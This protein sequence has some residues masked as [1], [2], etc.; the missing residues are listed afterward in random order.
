METHQRNKNANAKIMG[1][2]GQVFLYPE[3]FDTLLYFSQLLQAE[4]IRCG[5]EHWRRNRTR[6][7]G[8]VYWQLDDCWPTASWSS[9]DYFG[10]WKALHYVAKRFFSPVMISCLEN[11][12]PI[13]GSEVVD[14]PSLVESTARL[15]VV[16]ESRQPVEGT[17][18]W[19]LCDAESR[20]LQQGDE[21]L[22]IQAL[23]VAWL[24]KMVFTGIDCLRDHLSF[25]YEVG[26]AIISSGSVLFTAPKHY[27]FEQPRLRGTREGDKLV[28]VA[29]RFAKWVEIIPDH[30]AVFSDNF[31]DMEAGS[32]EV[33]IVEGDFDT[34]KLRCLN[35]THSVH[36]TLIPSAD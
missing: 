31:F 21:P 16:N 24:D 26:G 22:Q 35:D 32:V 17:V 28:I 14:E 9:I 6:C 1:Y 20:V 15:C 33:T 7:M 4:A 11:E 19:R 13:S 8:A 10:R 3:E 36:P 23:S 18:H 12:E 25:T 30:D 2:L 5:V 34:F 27:L 29:D